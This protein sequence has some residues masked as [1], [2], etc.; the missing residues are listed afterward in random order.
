MWEHCRSVLDVAP[1]L[2]AKILGPQCPVT[3]GVTVTPEPAAVISALIAD[4]PLCVPCIAEKVRLAVD[5]VESYLGR[6][7]RVI[8]LGRGTDRCR[9]CGNRTEVVSM[10]RP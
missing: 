3:R 6:I 1:R 10:F 9:A 7:A 5:E 2:T 8:V 4:Q